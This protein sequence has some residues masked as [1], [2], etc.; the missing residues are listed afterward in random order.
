MSF[1]DNL[2]RIQRLHALI[3]RKATGAPHQL[4]HRLDVS[5]ATVYRYL[6][7]LKALGAPL[8]YCRLRQTYYYENDFDLVFQVIS[9]NETT[10]K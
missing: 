6:E 3:R 7:E 9:K 10:R 8:A 5:R 4:A 2:D 1:L